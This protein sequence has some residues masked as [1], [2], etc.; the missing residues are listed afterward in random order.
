MS[1]FSAII[2]GKSIFPKDG[3]VVLLFGDWAMYTFGEWVHM[4]QGLLSLELV[5]SDA[6]FVIFI[7][8]NVVSKSKLLPPGR[9]WSCIRIIRVSV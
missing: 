6:L 4:D 3:W 2:P 7:L 9:T 1:M 8:F 5:L